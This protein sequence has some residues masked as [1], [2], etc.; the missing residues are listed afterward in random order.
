MPTG[1]DH[2]PRASEIVA[3]AQARRLLSAWSSEG[4]AEIGA[5]VHAWT[6]SQ[7]LDQPGLRRNDHAHAYLS[8]LPAGLVRAKFTTIT[9][10]IA[11][12][13]GARRRRFGPGASASTSAVP[14]RLPTWATSS[15]RRSHLSPTGARIPAFPA[16]P[17]DR[18]FVT[19]TLLPSQSPERADP[20]SS[21]SR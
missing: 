8:E 2:P 11:E 17:A 20:A 5:H 19:T 12:A 16:A 1:E 14:R 15:I 4:R 6:T 18:T 10:E 9:E 7:F 3:D 13:F 21:R